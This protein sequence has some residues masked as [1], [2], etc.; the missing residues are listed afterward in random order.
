MFSGEVQIQV[1]VII[2]AAGKVT[3]AEPLVS[4]G[5]I[6]EYLGKVAAAAARVWKFEPA[7]LDGQA[8]PSELLLQFRF[9][10]EK[11]KW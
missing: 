1:K 3:H 10:P 4:K 11:A 5:A 6:T 2:D 9:A 8:V 7:R